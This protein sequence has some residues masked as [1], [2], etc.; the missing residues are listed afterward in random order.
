MKSEKEIRKAI[1]PVYHD[2]LREVLAHLG[3]TFSDF[4]VTPEWPF[5]GSLRFTRN[6]DSQRFALRNTPKGWRATKSK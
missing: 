5:S 4:R 6:E 3:G 1:H 2:R